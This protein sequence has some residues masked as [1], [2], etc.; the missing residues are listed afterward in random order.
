MT[1]RSPLDLFPRFTRWLS[2]T[3]VTSRQDRRNTVMLQ[4]ILVAIGTISLIAAVVSA[5]SPQDQAQEAWIALAISAYAW[6]C[7]DLS[8]TRM[9]RLAAGLTVAGS[10]LLIG[11]SYYSYGL[12]AQPSMLMMHLLPLLLAGL[13]L[14]RA[15][16]W[17]TA[18]ANGLW[19]VL[20]AWV[21]LQRPHVLFSEV[22][23]SLIGSSLN[24]LVLAAVLDRM[25]LSLQK[26]TARSRALDAVNLELKR[27]IA[28]KDRAYARLVHTQRMETIGRLSAGVA[29]DFN[30][31]LS[32]ITGWA[33]SPAATDDPGSALEGIKRAAQRGAMLSRRL[34]SFGRTRARPVDIAEFD[35]GTVL[36]EMHPLVAPMFPSGIKVQFVLPPTSLIVA[37]DRDELELALLNMASNSV[38][39]M[40]H[41]GRFVVSLHDDGSHALLRVEDSGSGMPPEVLSRLFEPFFTTKPKDEG[42]GIGMTIVHRFV[43]DCGGSIAVNSRPGEG[44]C[45]DIRL[46]LVGSA[47]SAA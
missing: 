27:Q 22:M 41:G 12:R 11:A 6:A 10:L 42:T 2:R 37:A 46:P 9:Y 36:E 5:F 24:F 1:T 30:H 26:A 35:L 40:P 45:I 28:E 38:D 17:W 31:V 33:S 39:A 20:G 29:H 8:R 7:F 43:V 21:D 44:T 18:L 47:A 25:I 15:A 4:T 13:L 23:S 32:I 14:G 16:V 19:L 34:L 3:R